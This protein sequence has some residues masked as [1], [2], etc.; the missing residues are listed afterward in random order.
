MNR[1]ESYETRADPVKRDSAVAKQRKTGAQYRRLRSARD[2]RLRSDRN[3]NFPSRA[4]K[5]RV[6]AA[7]G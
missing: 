5:H 3:F 6:R 2:R 4:S 1:G 7:V